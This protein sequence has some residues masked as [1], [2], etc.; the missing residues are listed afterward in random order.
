MCIIIDNTIHFLYVK[1]NQVV[2]QGRELPWK[3]QSTAATAVAA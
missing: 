2:I 1:P 3:I